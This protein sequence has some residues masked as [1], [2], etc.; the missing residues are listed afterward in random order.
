MNA[1]IPVI[2]GAHAMTARP[3]VARKFVI[4]AVVAWTALTNGVAKHATAASFDAGAIT[5]CTIHGNN[6]TSIAKEEKSLRCNRIP[7][8]RAA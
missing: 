1:A 8:A 7:L 6:H 3:R 4:R 5:T 2:P